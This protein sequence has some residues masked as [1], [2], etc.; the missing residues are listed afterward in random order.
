MFWWHFDPEYV[1]CVL[2]LYDLPGFVALLSHELV[3]PDPEPGN[4]SPCDAT[5]FPGQS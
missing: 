2:V 1:R 4:R 5:D 3:L